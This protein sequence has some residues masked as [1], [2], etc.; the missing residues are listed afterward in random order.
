MS[1]DETI[2]VYDAQAADYAAMT[3]AYNG[4]DPR[5]EAF[6]AACPPGGLVLDLGCGPGAS[7]ATMARA[8]LVVE[9]VDASAEM[10]RMAGALPGVT[11]RQAAFS[12]I[13]AVD[14]YDGI[15]ANF[16]LLHAPRADF[17]GHLAAL[18]RALKPGGRFMIGLKLGTGEGRDRLG[19]YYTYYTE[20][21]L[22][23]YLRQAG[24]TP[25]ERKLGRGTGLDGSESDWIS[26][27]A[28]G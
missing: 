23:G 18:H 3:D 10:V 27:A 14:R 9:A 7:A 13:D 1:D 2:G 20:S 4:T 5:L 17:P 6:I 21:E 28:H 12:D 25:V 16:S 19:R 26:V 15:W 24:F 11:A 22:D 8:G